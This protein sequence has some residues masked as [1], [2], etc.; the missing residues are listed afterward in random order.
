[1]GMAGHTQLQTYLYNSTTKSR[2]ILKPGQS[3]GEIIAWLQKEIEQ[4]QRSSCGTLTTHQTTL[5][6]TAPAPPSSAARR[7]TVPPARSA[8]YPCWTCQT[9]RGSFDL[10]DLGEAPPNCA[11]HCYG[12]RCQHDHTNSCAE[13]LQWDTLVCAV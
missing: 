1:M 8:Q 5:F 3:E 12:Q 2:P 11:E 10:L 6:S 7:V 13:C 4:T 9:A